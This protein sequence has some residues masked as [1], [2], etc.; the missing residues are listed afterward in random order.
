[1]RRWFRYANLDQGTGVGAAKPDEEEAFP[2]GSIAIGHRFGRAGRLYAV[3][4]RRFFA[5][6]QSVII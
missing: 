3:V 1:M 2:G 6:E 4:P 5:A